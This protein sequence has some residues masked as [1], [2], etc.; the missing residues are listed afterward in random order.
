MSRSAERSTGVFGEPS[1][2]ASGQGL[3]WTTPA[4]VS[5]RSLFAT[6]DLSPDGTYLAL[7]LETT[8][9][10]ANQD[11]IIE[12]GAVKFRGSQV[13]DTFHSLVNPYR[14][15]P[16]F[17]RRYTGITQREVDSAPPFAAV[18]GKL[19][20]FVGKLPVIGHNIPF[21]LGF[22]AKHGLPLTNESLDTWEI[23]WVLLPSAHG[24]SLSDL[25]RFLGVA[26]PRPHRALDDA[27]ATQGVFIAL[28]ERAAQLKP[29]PRFFI[30]Q[31]ASQA[32][33]NTGVLLGGVGSDTVDVGEKTAVDMAGLDLDTL[34]ERLGSDKTVLTSRQSGP[35]DE[36]VLVGLLSPGGAFERD[37]PGYEH[38]PQQVE[39]LRAVTRAFND[40]TRLMVEAGTGVGKSLAYLLPAILFAVRN[41]KRVVVSTNTINL[42]EQLLRKDI[43]QV[44]KL[45]ESQG[46]IPP[47]EFRA[48]YLK[49]RANYLCLQQW[50]RLVR[51]GSLSP[52]EARI[53][54]KTRVWMEETCT[55]DRGEIN[56][57]GKDGALWSRLSTEEGGRCPG[58]RQGLC[59]LRSARERAKNAHLVVVNHA[60]LLSDL[61]MEG[62]ILSQY[63]HL[64]VDEAHHLEEEATRHLGF[65]IP[66]G[67]LNDE[68]E[69]LA[70]LLSEVRIRLRGISLSQHQ[71]Q[72]GLEMAT[73][74]ESWL[75]TAREE[76]A[77]LWAV[78]ERFMHAHQ[79][80]GDTYLQLRLSR[81]VRSQP[82]WSSVEVAWENTDV[83]LPEGLRRVEALHQYI[84]QLATGS[85][86]EYEAL[87]NELSAWMERQEELRKRLR[88]LLGVV[89][90]EERVDWIS[91]NS[92]SG[93]LALH[94]APL[95]VGPQLEEG[96]F[97]RDGS[98]VLTSATLTSQESFEYMRQ[99]VGFTEGEELL[100]G[101]PF[102]YTRA[103]MLVIPSDM[104]EP[105][106]HNYINIL[107]Q[108][109][110]SLGK[111]LQGRTL[112]LFTSHSSLRATQ[113]AVL[114]PLEADGIKVL[115]QGVDGPPA[116]LVQQFG[117]NPKTVLLGTSS[118]WEG[119]DLSGGIVKA[120]VLARLPFNV[121]TEPVFAA[122]SSLYEDPFREYALPQAVL[123]LRQGFGRLIR[124][125]G[126]KGV[127][128]LLDSRVLK[129]NYGRVFLDSLPPCTVR[130]EPVAALPTLARQWVEG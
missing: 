85:D 49:G 125:K 112:V 16:D 90:S 108:A 93:A 69:S 39:M 114:G 31:V 24:Y 70:R 41:G 50:S 96:L 46:L 97:S 119:V 45:L 127:V 30:S 14:Q 100:L 99:R 107:S 25:S 15:I 63:D 91:Q 74:V 17:V 22:L 10:D 121:P 126:D 86:L 52:Q 104:P 106:N 88:E 78:L 61:A 77:R 2:R 42:Q 92:D 94:S 33:W 29:G 109:L 101:S 64:I 87:L 89:P 129:R 84:E 105:S 110:V 58:F 115:A 123:R 4:E 20:A 95:E 26:H 35:L 19:A 55:G 54:A 72:R 120:L 43:P 38:R 6:P 102:D 116:Q 11:D 37:F 51:S 75:P 23:A 73:Q 8:G 122:R 1:A 5:R 60:L 98:L 124:S 21:D 44:A 128:V 13:L 32:G 113:Q 103:V 65:E 82:G 118:F 18:A 83:S 3:T 117:R 47:G 27:A 48:T 56:L 67:R 76:W 81:S 28:L 53:L 66:Q 59:F 57:A 40:S 36:E 68:M 79:E 71:R 62:S 80:E 7:D 130:R 9:L 12:V 34:S 111:A